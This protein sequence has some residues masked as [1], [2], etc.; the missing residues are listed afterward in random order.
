MIDTF[1]TAYQSGQQQDIGILKSQLGELVAQYALR[2]Q[3]SEGT[4]ANAQWI[5][6]YLK[7]MD[8][9]GQGNALNGMFTHF[10]KILVEE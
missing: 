10:E 5:L 1:K 2:I 8:P 4:D 6:D 9:S 3:N 7:S